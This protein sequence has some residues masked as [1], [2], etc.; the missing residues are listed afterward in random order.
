MR[1]HP[2][3]S[4]HPA[5]LT[6]CRIIPACPTYRPW[7]VGSSCSRNACPR[8][9]G[10]CSP[11]FCEPTSP[12]FSSWQLIIGAIDWCLTNSDG[13]WL[14]SQTGGKVP[15]DEILSSEVVR[16]LGLIAQSLRLND[17]RVPES[18]HPEVRRAVE[19]ERANFR[20][21]Y[22]VD[23]GPHSKPRGR[24]LRLQLSVAMDRVAA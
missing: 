18:K 4:P 24:M 5:G 21:L 17:Q 9:P 10:D 13:S 2:R 12:T 23:D 6:C 1:A 8:M 11:R 15:H 19:A 3:R 14:S 22:L 20:T 16:C 7:R